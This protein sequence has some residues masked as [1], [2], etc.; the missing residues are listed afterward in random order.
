MSKAD[1][2]AE[3]SRLYERL[4]EPVTP[5]VWRLASESRLRELIDDAKRRLQARAKDANASANNIARANDYL[6]YSMGGTRN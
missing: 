3:L 4:G 1:L 6:W 5:L 2:V